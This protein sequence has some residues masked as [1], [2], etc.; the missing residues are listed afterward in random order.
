MTPGD[1]VILCGDHP[2]CGETGVFRR[3]AMTPFGLRPEV[4]LA[5]NSRHF[6]LKADQVRL[7]DTRDTTTR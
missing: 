1:R 3:M 5:D 7:A 6:V 4:Q 2:R